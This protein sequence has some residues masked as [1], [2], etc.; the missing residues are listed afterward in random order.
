MR[1]KWSTALLKAYFFNVATAGAEKNSEG[2]GELSRLPGST[3]GLLLE[4]FTTQARVDHIKGCGSDPVMA[5]RRLLSSSPSASIR[6]A[7]RL[8]WIVSLLV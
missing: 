3:I 7:R 2:E 6:P 1:F 4:L 5:W 8:G